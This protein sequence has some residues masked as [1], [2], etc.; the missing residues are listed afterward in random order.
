MPPGNLLLFGCDFFSKKKASEIN[1]WNDMVERFRKDFEQVAI[2]SVN[3]RA[4]AEEKLFDNV[5]LYNVKPYYIGNARTWPDPEY[6]GRRFHR[7]PFSTVYKTYSLLKYL[8]I[9]DQLISKHSVGIVH[10]VRVF[11]LQNSRLTKRHP[12]VLFSITVP[13]H[14]DR[15]FPLHYLYHRIKNMALSPMDMVVATSRATR[16]RLRDLGLDRDSLEV[17][18]WSSTSDDPPLSPETIEGIRRRYRIPDRK[19]VV[20]WSGP[21]QDT[22][23]SEFAFSHDVA[24]RVTARTDRFV[25]VFA[26]KP[27]RLRAERGAASPAAGIRMLE[28]VRS[29]FL[30][31]AAISDILLSPVCNPNRT[32]APPLTWI[33]MMRRGVP[34]I[35]TAVAG[36]DELI[37][38]G[39]NGYVVDGI[40]SA[41]EVLAGLDAADLRRTAAAGKRTVDTEYNFQVIS[42]RYTAMWRAGL[43][44]KTKATQP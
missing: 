36:V 18:P 37:T 9:F 31:L 29:E 11:G 26:F 19:Q 21:L 24:R 13:T 43:S 38:H 40:E 14:V 1:F 22:G 4:I 33:E 44:G 35:T 10:Y 39:K 15:G 34:V 32:V 23:S 3:N 42:R 27:A 7:L 2:L 30:D 20:L 6:T 5:F 17:I 8:P 41:A 12:H 16:D 25:F 28:T